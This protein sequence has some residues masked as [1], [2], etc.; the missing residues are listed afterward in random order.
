MSAPH[1]HG[2]AVENVEE[3]PH[4]V[5]GAMDHAVNDASGRGLSRQPIMLSCKGSSGSARRGG[6]RPARTKPPPTGDDGYAARGGQPL[7]RRVRPRHGLHERHGELP[8]HAPARP[9]R[10]VRHFSLKHRQRCVNEFAVRQ[11]LR[12]CD[13]IDRMAAI[14][15]GMAGKRLRHVE[16]TG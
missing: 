10:D 7:G 13:A 14:A 15:H 16:L 4:S 12:E 2:I 1:R 9:P 5:V 8:L 6:P 3:I 11:G